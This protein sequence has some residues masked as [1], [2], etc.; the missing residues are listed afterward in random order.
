MKIKILLVEYDSH[1]IDAITSLFHPDV[2]EFSVAGNETEA[3]TLLNKKKFDMVISE[4]M[5]PKSHGFILSRYINE[6]YP[7]IKV[8]VI[9]EK[10]DDENHKD[11]AF[12][13]GA[14]EFIE[15]PLNK[16][17]FMEKVLFH[18]NANEKKKAFEDHIE[19]TTNLYVLPFLAEI[20]AKQ[21]G[22]KSEEEVFNEIIESMKKEDPSDSFEIE[23]DE[24]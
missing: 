8:I 22:G 16:E 13:Y 11:E 24:E 2:V 7:K 3:K 21:T 14:C 4:A 12:Q 1:M 20:K 9:S 23:L 10:T 15:K 5:L 18:I 17:K 19:D 6:N